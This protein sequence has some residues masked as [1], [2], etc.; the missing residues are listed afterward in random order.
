MSVEL[1]SINILYVFAD[2]VP[3]EKGS[4]LTGVSATMCGQGM[5]ERTVIRWG[6][7]IESVLPTQQVTR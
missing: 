2:P 3:G 1:Y 6:V 7:A 5:C 4:A